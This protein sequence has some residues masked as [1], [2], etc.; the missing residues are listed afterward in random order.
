[1]TRWN[2]IRSQSAYAFKTMRFTIQPI[3]DFVQ[4]FWLYPLVQHMYKLKHFSRRWMGFGMGLR[5]SLT[6]SPTLL[7]WQIG[8]WMMGEFWGD[9]T[10]ALIQNNTKN[11]RIPSR[12]IDSLSVMFKHTNSTLPPGL[13]TGDLRYTEFSLVA[14]VS[15]PWG[16]YVTGYCFN[17][18][19]PG[20]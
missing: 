16:L 3:R 8:L 2:N 4:Q 7:K 5:K 20:T 11:N 6:S 14:Y 13:S 18:V 17:Q 12:T 9:W 15:H 19:I 10:N 1:M